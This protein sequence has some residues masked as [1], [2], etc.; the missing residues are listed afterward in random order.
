M[1]QKFVI[2]KAASGKPLKRIFITAEEN[3][4]IIGDPERLA[5]IKSGDHGIACVSYERV[6][7]FEE[8]VY[9]ELVREWETSKATSL[10]VWKSLGHIELPNEA[11]EH[12]CQF[13]C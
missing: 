4:I 1:L 2:L 6:F 10:D 8:D 11:D 13:W 3:E 12:S 7:N 9:I 5:E